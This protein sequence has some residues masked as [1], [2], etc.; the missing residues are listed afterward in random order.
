MKRSLLW[1]DDRFVASDTIAIDDRGVTV[2]DGVFETLGAVDGSPRHLRRHLAR[3]AHTVERLD[4]RLPM[5]LGRIERDVIDLAAESTQR[6]RIR[7]T[8]TRGTPGVEGSPSRFARVIISSE[9]YELP[10]RTIRLVTVPWQRNEQ[11]PLTGIKSTSWAENA[12]MLRYARANG[13]DDVLLCNTRGEV[14]ETATANLFVSMMGE[15]ATPPLSSGCLPG[16]AREV[17]LGFRG[18]FERSMPLGFFLSGEELFSVSSL[19]GARR[20]ISVDG[21]PVGSGNADHGS[22]DTELVNEYLDAAGRYTT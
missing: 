12:E 15:L 7:I 10:P 13:A 6:Q 17:V 19:A 8:V 11:S 14:C 9:P 21:R 18:A 20:I 22:G 5:E 1:V 4:L 3:L 2:G 16:I